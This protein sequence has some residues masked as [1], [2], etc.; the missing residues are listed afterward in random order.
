MMEHILTEV[1]MRF[2]ELRRRKDTKSYD[3]LRAEWRET[4]T[5]SSIP[6][7]IIVLNDMTV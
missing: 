2:D 6:Q 3:A 7:E 1:E 5:E 4:Y